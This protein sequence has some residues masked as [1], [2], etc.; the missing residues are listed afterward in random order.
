[1]IFQR[2]H[3]KRKEGRVH[4]YYFRFNRQRGPVDALQM[5]LQG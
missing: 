5:R 1:M 4:N 3:S 2:L